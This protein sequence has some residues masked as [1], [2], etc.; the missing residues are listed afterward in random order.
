MT[1]E[2]ARSVRDLLI[3][4]GLL[5]LNNHG[6]Q[7]FSVRRVASACS[8]SCAAPYKHFE[9]KTHFIASIIEHVINLWTSYIPAVVEKHPNDLRQ[10]LVEISV[11]YVHFLVENSHFRSIIMLKEPGLDQQYAPLRLHL[12][13][14]SRRLVYQYC[15]LQNIPH[16]VMSRKLFIIR[17]LLYGAALMF[18]NG[19]I[20]YT[21]EN[22]DLIRQAINREFD[23][24]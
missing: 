24:P 4:A 15:E 2:P 21:A 18:D 5:E 3:Q 12:S 17:S 23:L 19:E 10:Q 7:D 13:N 20:E 11:R 14:S 16:E 9:D 22:V 8:I 1:A 6:I